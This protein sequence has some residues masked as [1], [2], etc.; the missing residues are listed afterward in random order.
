MQWHNAQKQARCWARWGSARPR[1]PSPNPSDPTGLSLP[2]A[3]DGSSVRGT[4]PLHDHTDGAGVCLMVLKGE[5]AGAEEF[6][7]KLVL[8]LRR[9]LHE[10][11]SQARGTATASHSPP[12]VTRLPQSQF[13]G[14]REEHQEQ[15][16]DILTP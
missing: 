16:A 8:L 13:T 11:G 14:S 1:L 15:V 5:H 3:A 9:Q 4:A 2:V 7:C 12:R 6:S 10:T